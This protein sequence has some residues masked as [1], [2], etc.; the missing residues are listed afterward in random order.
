MTKR[1]ALA[2]A[3]VALMGAIR[4]HYDGRR[5]QV[6]PIVVATQQPRQPSEPG[7]AIAGRFVVLGDGKTLFDHSTGLVWQYVAPDTPMGWPEASDYCSQNKPALPGVGWRLPNFNELLSLVDLQTI[8]AVD[9]V[10]F[11][12]PGPACWTS[13]P[14]PGGAEKWSINFGTGTTSLDGKESNTFVRCVR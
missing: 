12:S 11:P 8:P 6:A 4:S 10:V 2:F 1:S 9:S 5:H 3:T 13:T 14:W 7:A